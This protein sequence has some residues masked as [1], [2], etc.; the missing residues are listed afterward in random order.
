MDITT[1]TPPTALSA[2]RAALYACFT[3]ARDVLFD[4]CDAL[5]TSPGARS[6]VALSQAPCVQRQWPR[7]YE[8]L[9]DGPRRAADGPLPPLADLARLYP[10]R[11][12]IEHGYRFDKQDLLLDG[13]A[14][15]HAGADGTLDSGGRRRP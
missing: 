13:P 15:A 7:V 3:R 2:Y 10:R 6:F 5:A 1:S 4:L 11:F 8:A 12:S 9:E 14:C